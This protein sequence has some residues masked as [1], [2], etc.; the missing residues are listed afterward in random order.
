MQQ[1]NG[2]GV[3]FVKGAEAMQQRNGSGVDFVKGQKPCIRG[4]DVAWIL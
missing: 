1:R 3:G 2:S 4:M